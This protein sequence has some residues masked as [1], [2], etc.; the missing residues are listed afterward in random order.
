MASGTYIRSIIVG[1]YFYSIFDVSYTWFDI[2]KHSLAVNILTLNLGIHLG[3]TPWL[4]ENLENANSSLNVTIDQ[5]TW[6]ASI[7]QIGDL[8]GGS[9]VFLAGNHIGRRSMLFC[10]LILLLFGWMMLLLY[11]TVLV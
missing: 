7:P 9:I 8:I 5:I 2:S 1:T 10:S 3:W 11:D 6:I 4:I